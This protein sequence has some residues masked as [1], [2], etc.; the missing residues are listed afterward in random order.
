MNLN[1]AFMQITSAISKKFTTVMMCNCEINYFGRAR[2]YLGEGDRLVIIKNDLS[3]IVHKSQGRNPV[4]W[5]SNTPEI[6]TEMQIDYFEINAKCI[7]PKEE[8]SINIFEVHSLISYP[9]VD[10]EQIKIVGS[11]RDMSDMIY[12]N[13]SLISDDFKPISREEKTEYGF[14]DVFGYDKSNNFVIIECKR[15]TAGLDAI[16]QL[17]RYVEKVKKSKGTNNIIGIIAAPNISPNAMK[18]L[19][20]WGF[21]YK[22]INPPKNFSQETDSQ[23]KIDEYQ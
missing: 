13:P 3:I 14:L 18:M 1:D 7:K 10:T 19:S 21:E 15:F 11:E 2:S 4:N 23:K 6:T 22:C 5:M 17:R 8:L 16:T 20:D 9:L 12:N